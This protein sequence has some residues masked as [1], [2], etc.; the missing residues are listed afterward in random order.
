MAIFR[1][2]YFPILE[3]RSDDHFVIRS[4]DNIFFVTADRILP[5]LD[6]SR[7]KGKQAG[8][9]SGRRALGILRKYRGN[10]L[11]LAIFDVD[12]IEAVIA[13]YSIKT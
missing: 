5:A 4:T 12:Q 2:M 11:Y 3:W 10:V 7:S 9:R 13:S 1:V 8:K 6:L